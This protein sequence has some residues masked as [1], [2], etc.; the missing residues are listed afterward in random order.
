MTGSEGL[1]VKRV[2]LISPGHV[3]F[4]PR[5][6]KEAN[7]L[8]SAGYSVHVIAADN[9][10][11]ARPLDGPILQA[12]AWSF[13]LVGGGLETLDFL[14]RARTKVTKE[15]LS[16]SNPTRLR[17]HEWAHH[18]LTGLL[19][20]AARRHQ[21]DL[22][23]AH[24]I[25]ALPAA[26]AAAR[27]HNSIWGFDA[28]DYHL[29]EFEPVEL[30]GVP[31]RAV[32]WIEA[33]YLPH[34][35]HFTAASDGIA[36]AYAKHYKT[37]SPQVILNVF[38]RANAP[39]APTKEGRARPGPSIYWFS[40]TIGVNRGLECAVR[41]IAQARSKPHLYLRGNLQSGI[42]AKLTEFAQ[43]LGVEDRIHYLPVAPGADMERLASEY[44]VGLVAETCYTENRQ[45]ALTNKLFSFLLAGLPVVASD[46]PAHRALAESC[47]AIILYPVDSSA[48]LAKAIDDLLLNPEALERA[49]SESWAAGQDRYNWDLE[50]KKLIHAVSGHIGPPTG[51]QG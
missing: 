22:Y 1:T 19:K 7:A 34:V 4:N 30:K 28:E 45:I 23:I 37:S 33:A 36:A 15:I 13:E 2:C 42:K 46:T 14:R 18:S 5:L 27:R 35:T 49:R 6:V 43:P 9:L 31:A 41:A 48:E 17:L 11:H 26:Y 12:A 21:A 20:A 25:A 24:Y 50:Q 8:S 29:G 16:V 38:P 47:G 51:E 32:R 44:D 10:K 40:Q 39:L 3:A